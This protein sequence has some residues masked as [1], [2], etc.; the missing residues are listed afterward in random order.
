ML[1]TALPGLAVCIRRLH[2]TD[3]SGWAI[4]V[5]MI[6]FVGGIICLVWYA[7]PSQNEDNQFGP[8]PDSDE[9]AAD[10][11]EAASDSDEAAPEA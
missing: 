7:T 1:G 9:A 11:D 2:D 8:V 10:D 6:P 5:N 4:L 3:H